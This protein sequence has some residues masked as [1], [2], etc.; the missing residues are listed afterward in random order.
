MVKFGIA[1]GIFLLRSV[2]ISATEECDDSAYLQRQQSQPMTPVQ[3]S[4]TFMEVGTKGSIEASPETLTCGSSAL[5]G[6]VS[7]SGSY[8][9]SKPWYVCRQ[10]WIETRQMDVFLHVMN[11]GTKFLMLQVL[12]IFHLGLL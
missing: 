7:I 2:I 5:P 3:P 10:Q 6:T 12:T 1:F 4:Y 11:F 8:A 9:A